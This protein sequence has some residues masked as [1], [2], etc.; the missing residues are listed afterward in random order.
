[1]SV[2]RFPLLCLAF[3]AGCAL[4]LTAASAA[5]GSGGLSLIVEPDQGYQPIYTL[6]ASA[7]HELD[8][9]MYE[10]ADAKAEQLLAADARRGVVVRVLLDR[11]YIG[12]YNE[13]TFSYL[14]Q[15]GVHV[16]WA[17][18]QVAITHEKSFVI[19]RRT[20][21]IM[22]GNLTSEYYSTTRD[23]AVVDGNAADV[24]AI[25]A[26]FD[27]DWANQPG[28]VPD[29]NDLVWSPGSE[30][31]L[32]SL[33][34]SAH[35]SLLVENEEMS[36]SGI[37]TA[38]EAA[39]QRGVTVDLVM[40]RS[41]EWDDAFDALVRAGVHVRTYSSSAALYIH[42]KVI[43]VDD[44]RVFIG[45]ENFSVGSMQYNREL[46]LITSSPTILAGIE[47]TL[48]GDFDHGQSW[49]P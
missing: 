33:I 17:S 27:L 19:D 20:A 45:S 36:A 23:F 37:I 10:F 9:T 26:T 30:P 35:R 18:S 2:T 32:V 28:A 24:G 25:E 34:D 16:R 15:H 3:L 31:T 38:L 12:S 49:Y 13:A 47:R 6:L 29:G 21:V 8:L 11:S 43:D 14:Q 44:A 5:I 46:G 7:K 39:A 1:M 22:T 48:T 40:E 4:A 41:S 42:A